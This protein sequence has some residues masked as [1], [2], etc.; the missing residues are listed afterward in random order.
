MSRAHVRCAPRRLP[1]D[2]QSLGPAA[3][4]CRG[5]QGVVSSTKEKEQGPSEWS[6]REHGAAG[7]MCQGSFER[8]GGQGAGEIDREAGTWT[9]SGSGQLGNSEGRWRKEVK[10]RDKGQGLSDR[11][12]GTNGGDG[13]VV[14]EQQRGRLFG[15]RK[16]ARGEGLSLAR[17]AST[18][19]VRPVIRPRSR[20][21]PSPAIKMLIGPEP[22]AAP[23]RSPPGREQGPVA[24][25]MR[26]PVPAPTPD[27]AGC[28]SAIRGRLRSTPPLGSDC[29]AR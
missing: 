2:G 11:V 7:H 9:V 16:G 22:P 20:W 14:G 24:R 19:R 18:W 23:R 28:G 10:T 15:G 13:D 25:W 21:A 29:H 3:P 26:I 1:T 6:P 27:L 4:P 5:P 12:T 8:T 17:A